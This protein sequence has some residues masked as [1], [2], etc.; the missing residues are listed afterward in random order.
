MCMRAVRAH[1]RTCTHRTHLIC[2][3]RRSSTCLLSVYRVDGSDGG[4][5]SGGGILR[6][7]TLALHPCCAAAAAAAT[8]PSI[9]NCRVLLVCVRRRSEG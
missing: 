6:G 5:V 4:G 8:M 9:C 1:V 7:R 3:P 2:V